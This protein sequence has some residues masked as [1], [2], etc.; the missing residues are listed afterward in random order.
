MTG[1]F[2][3]G[4]THRPSRDDGRNYVPLCLPTVPPPS[5]PAVILPYSSKAPLFS[6]SLWQM[7]GGEGE[8]RQERVTEGGEQT[9]GELQRQRLMRGFQMRAEKRQMGRGEGNRE[10]ELEQ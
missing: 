2:S 1:V 6:C 4:D 9:S 10:R 8:G 3:R 7:E 5:L